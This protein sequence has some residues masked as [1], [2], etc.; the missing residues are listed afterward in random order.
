MNNIYAPKQ[1]NFV[2]ASENGEL[3][4]YDKV[5]GNARNVIPSYT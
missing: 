1:G 4:T 2:I 3:R 5:G